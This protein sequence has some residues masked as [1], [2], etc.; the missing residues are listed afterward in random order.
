MTFDVLS[1]IINTN[2]K[3]TIRNKKDEKNINKPEEFSNKYD[4][5]NK[6]INNTIISL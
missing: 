2:K 1:Y 5:N 3:N 6:I 4:K